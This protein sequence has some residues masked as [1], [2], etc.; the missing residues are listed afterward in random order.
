MDEFTGKKR[1]RF[2]PPVAAPFATVR[3]APSIVLTYAGMPCPCR[4]RF[5]YP[6]FDWMKAIAKDLD[7]SEIDAVRRGQAFATLWDG[8]QDK[9]G[10][11]QVKNYQGMTV[12]LYPTKGMLIVEGALPT[13]ANGNNLHLLTYPK[14]VSACVGLA[15]AVGLPGSRL[16]LVGL[17]LSNDLDSTTPPQPLL[18][19]LLHHKGSKFTAR[20][21]PKGV[22]R[23]LEYFA[24]HADYG[25]KLYDKGTWEKRHGN[26]LPAGQYR[27][28][29]EVVCGRARA[30]NNLWNRSETT[31]ADLTSLEFY[32]A[33]A[34]QLEQQWLAIVRTQ[35]LD[36]T[37]L[38]DKDRLL[39]GAG[40][41]PEFW[42]G[43]RADR[44][45]VTY[46]RTR[47]QY[48]ELVEASAKRVGQ[49]AYAQRFPLALAA[50]LPPMAT[51]QNDTL[52]HTSSLLDLPSMR[53]M[54]EPAPPLVNDGGAGTL[55]IDDERE[56]VTPATR[57]CQT[58][59]RV[60]TSDSNRA[61]FCSEREWGAAAKKCRN[62][63]S[64]PVHNTARAVHRILSPWAPW[65]LFPQAPFI[66]I[67]VSIRAAVLAAVA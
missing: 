67:P 60:L 51:A 61:K 16:P 48:R 25:A 40:V 41:N 64:N 33:A 62:A 32:A 53:V 26:H 65:S 46:K 57:C 30:I 15:A 34:A 23:P 39:L 5:S 4:S 6:M 17:E 36:F 45:L 66:R 56:P 59:G 20:K 55:P 29:F 9:H 28:R 44:A 52:L 37:G 12:T 63:A 2:A 43:L 21:P 18:Q 58:C 14:M 3:P 1:E 54:K 27:V 13:F 7:A 49:D 10:R 11:E 22:A 31:L 8:V 38:K 35:P 50:L 24:S 42:R 19:S 47:K